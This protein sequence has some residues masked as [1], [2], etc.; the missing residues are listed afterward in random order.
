MP[1]IIRLGHLKI[2]IFAD[3]HHPPH[4]HIVTADHEALVRISDFSLMAGRIDRRS[5]D[6]ALAWAT[7]HQE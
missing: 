7:A 5:Y 2:Q 1:A 6:M 3:D 4:F